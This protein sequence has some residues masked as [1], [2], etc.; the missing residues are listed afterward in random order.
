MSIQDEIKIL[1]GVRRRLDAHHTAL[2]DEVEPQ[3]T[4]P[5]APEWWHD[6]VY[7]SERL[8]F[9]L[10][11]TELDIKE[12][13]KGVRYEQA[14]RDGMAKKPAKKKTAKKK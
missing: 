12:L 7:L 10:N 6:W 11:T 2:V 9:V 5:K 4:R 8:K 1:Q 13:K 3:R 14:M